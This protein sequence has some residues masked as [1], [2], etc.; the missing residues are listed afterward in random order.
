MKI[1]SAKFMRGVVGPDEL[2]EDGTPQVA[3]IGRSNVGKSSVINSLTG[4]KG[5]ART[6]AFPGRTREINIFWINKSLYLVDLPGYGYAK[7]SFAGRERI[8]ELIHWY[9]IGFQFPQKK[10]LLII[11]ANVGPMAKDLEMLRGLEGRDPS[12]GSGQG[13]SVN[14]G[15][16]KNIVIV[17]N[18]IDKIKK[19]DY[20]KQLKDIQ[21]IIGKYKVIPYSAQMKIGVKEL[22]KEI[23]D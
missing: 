17:A 22:T 19:S 6:S 10:V 9:L 8:Q 7:A 21:D 5:L 15:R 20:K 12:A 2:L 11:D 16:G 1:T 3:F 23:L 14:S 4:E 13:P 18:K